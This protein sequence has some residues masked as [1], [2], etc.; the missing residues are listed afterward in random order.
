[1]VATGNVTDQLA[2]GACQNGSTLGVI[3]LR[4]DT[5]ARRSDTDSALIFH[6]LHGVYRLRG[7]VLSCRESRGYS[8]VMETYPP[9]RRLCWAASEPARQSAEASYGSRQEPRS[10]SS[11]RWHEAGAVAG[12]ITVLDLPLSS[13]RPRSSGEREP[14]RG[15]S[16]QDGLVLDL[17]AGHRVNPEPAKQRG[18]VQRGGL[19]PQLPAGR[20]ARLPG[21]VRCD[22]RGRGRLYA[23]VVRRLAGRCGVRGQE[24]V[25]RRPELGP[26][27]ATGIP[28]AGTVD[29]LRVV[30]LTSELAHARGD[31]EDQPGRWALAPGAVDRLHVVL[32]GACGYQRPGP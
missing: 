7:T 23:R 30:H 28:L 9:Q 22:D 31:A 24:C 21:T 26:G 27:R 8:W 13:G 29:A 25:L 2:K 15:P 11:S 18:G 17:G 1:M 19:R 12:L 14:A 20:R 3:K 4:T 10:C 16:D 5:D 32:E 6:C